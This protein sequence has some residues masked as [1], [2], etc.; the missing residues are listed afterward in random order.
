ML[1][2]PIDWNEFAFIVKL[3]FVTASYALVRC[4]L[5]SVLGV[6]MFAMNW[7]K[8]I[9]DMVDKTQYLFRSQA[10]FD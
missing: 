2:I 3:C 6:Y 10:E 7:G 4:F 1:L 8:A 5:R 9:C